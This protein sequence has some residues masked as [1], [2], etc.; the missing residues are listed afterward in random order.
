MTKIGKLCHIS[1]NVRIYTSTNLSDQDFKKP[2]NA[3]H[4][5][6]IIE[7]Y[8][9]IDANVFIGPGIIIGT[10][11]IVRA[12]SVVTH[13]LPPNSI[14]GGVPARNIRNKSNKPLLQ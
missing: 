2:L 3:R 10:N 9:W 8:C 5:N 4:E 6:L 11:S 14:V 7:D 13:N 1:H 12:N